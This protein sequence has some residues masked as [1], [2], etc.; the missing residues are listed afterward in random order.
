MSGNVDGVVVTAEAR[1]GTVGAVVYVFVGAWYVDGAIFDCG[2]RVC[3]EIAGLCGCRH[4]STLFENWRSDGVVRS[5][6]VGLGHYD[7]RPVAGC[8][9]SSVPAFVGRS[10]DAL[11][12]SYGW[13]W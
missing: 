6:S 4:H 1:G 13:R 12:Q 5:R 2:A 10:G 8:V 9:V 7:A 3:S 11:E